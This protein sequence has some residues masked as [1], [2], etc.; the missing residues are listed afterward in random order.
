[1]SEIF[2]CIKSLVLTVALVLVLQVQ[3]GDRT[4][5]N[6]AMAWVYTSQVTAPL[7]GVARGAAKLI[8]DGEVK[9]REQ[10][11]ELKRNI[12]DLF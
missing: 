6:H 3:V 4:L 12:S 11:R 9:A 1:M 2:F 8:R 5:E 7:N 10:I